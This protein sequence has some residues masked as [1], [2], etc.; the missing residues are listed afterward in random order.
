[1]RAHG[2]GSLTAD[3]LYVYPTALKA[4]SVLH[5]R[6]RVAGCLLGYR[7]TTFPQ[8]TDALARELGVSPRVLGP[9]MAAVVLARAL[10]RPEMPAA[11]RA[12]Q[13][14][15]VRELLAVI[16]EFKAAYLAPDDVAALAAQLPRGAAAARLAELGRVYAAYEAGLA[17]LDAVDRHGREWRVC[18]GLAAAEAASTRP[19]A[20]DGIG[21]IVFAEIYDFP[22]LQ[23]L[24]ATSLIR[25]VGDAELIAF[26]HPE[27][28][29]AT[30]FLDRT[31]NRFVG[32]PGIADQVL[33]SFV[34]RGGR[35]GSLAAALR[36]V[37]AAERPSAVAADASL[38][39]VVAPSRY[40]EVEA[41]V[42]DVRLRLERGER[43][44]RIA[45]LARDLGVYGDLIEDVCRRYRVPVY[46]RKGKPLVAN[47][48]VKACLNALRCVAEG[49][50]RARLEAVLDTDYLAAAPRGLVRTLRR[51]G[52]VAETARPLAECVTHRR[53]ALSAVAAADPERRRAAEA[54]GARLEAAGTRLL[55][56][57]D[58][59]RGLEGRRTVT[60]HVRTL[61]RTLRRLKL[62]P[63]PR[64]EVVPAAARRDARA[65][66]RFEE[67]L[68][69]L[70]GVCR[71]LGMEPMP[72]ADFIRLL[73][74]ALEPL[75]VE[76]PAERAGSV[77][78]LSVLDA[79]GLD[80]DAV[81]LL[82]L[83][84]G[85]FPAPR[86]ESPLWPDAMKREASRLAAERLRGK[87]G[88]RAR[89]L[90]LGGLL[91]TAREA[92]LEDPFLFFL[93][94]SMAE[95]ELVL[96]Y[97]AVNEKGNPTVPS[98]FV[99]EIRSCTELPEAV[100]DPTAL[101]P[102]ADACCEVAELIG[103]AALE[104]WS[105]MPGA[106][107]DRLTSAL[108]GARADLAGRVDAIDRRAA[109][110]ERRGRYFLSACGEPGKS[111]LADA[112]VGRLSADLGPLDARLAALAWSPARLEALGACG[113]RFYARDVL[114]LAADVDPLAEVGLAE[115]GTLVHAVLEGFLRAHPVL[116]AEL[117]AARALGRTFLEHFREHAAR[118]ILAKDPA[119]LSVAWRQ[120]ATA[121]DAL[122]VLEHGAQLRRARDGLVVERMLEAPVTR[123][124]TDPGGAMLT[125]AGKPDRVDVLRQGDQ[126]RALR[127]LDYKA[128]RK[129][130]D[131]AA[132]LDPAKALGRTS[133]QVPVY[134]L[135]ALGEVGAI[136]ADATL[137]GGYLVLFGERKEVVAE[138]T[139]QALDQV[140]RRIAALVARARQGRFDVDP[141]PCDPYC[142]YRAV[143]RYERPPLEE[144]AGSA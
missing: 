79:R 101:V 10:D 109:I 121:V 80:F 98:P 96:S 14:G 95:R 135:G 33:P 28:V 58:T 12:P 88:A 51:V 92:S 102:T 72:L 13:R 136:P 85:T 65:F 63:L 119:L 107:A 38:R 36:G 39:L 131:Y 35:Q 67:T 132:R 50:P 55:G 40:R 86:A 124:L 82:G 11:L 2:D 76:D 66:E 25:L 70:A 18:E 9:E 91:R 31:W 73:V 141:D 115:R 130:A 118:A 71:T 93:A 29:D 87:L 100:L 22:V 77:R 8:L 52:Y 90:A 78:A 83:D 5:E 111:A 1:V 26:A 49:F 75:E 94:L 23:F 21:R 64:D 110:E 133:F 6:A 16:A 60:G 127:V 134:L 20:L 139:P 54:E 74:A 116:P 19:R 122:V 137:E 126:V 62:R 128:S 89:G 97:P 105:A 144:E 45:L 37:F 123:T 61:R 30:R 103:R 24:I 46:F 112:F 3:T 114:G 106:P 15:L 59:L 104:R 27:N 57:I 120:V 81:Y 17:R 7:V 68:A 43:P 125:I 34:A 138:F 142:P 48:L 41:A 44:E 108:A 129:S 117:E 143:C 99:E 113:F 47:G 42:R 84:D 32:D 4:E 140:V 53:A 69:T 56:L